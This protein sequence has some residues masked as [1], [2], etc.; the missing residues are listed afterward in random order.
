MVAHTNRT[1]VYT[2]A[3]LLSL[4][5]GA[6]PDVSATSLFEVFID[7]TTLTGTDAVLAF[8][9]VDGDALANNVVTI[10]NFSTDGTL[11]A[12][13]ANPP[14]AVVG[15]FP[16]TVTIADTAL[17]NELLQG[18]TLDT[19]I[20]FTLN[21]TENFAGGLVPDQFSLFLLDTT[22]LPLFSTSDPTDAHALFAIDITGVAFG[23]LQRFTATSSPAATVRVAP[24]PEPGPL[25]LLTTGVGGLAA[26]RG[27]R[28]KR[29]ARQQQST[30][31]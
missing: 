16:G 28:Q 2:L 5:G 9:L 22:D 29:T 30:F 11:G 3:F 18:I 20:T 12:A 1:L 8:N 26:Y 4:C 7:T 24:V 14:S 19:T 13:V 6:V 23:N 27:W 21:L 15:A 31:L 17:F 10:A 25:L